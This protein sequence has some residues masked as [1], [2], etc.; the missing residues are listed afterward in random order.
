MTGRKTEREENG[1][2]NLLQTAFFVIPQ[3]KLTHAITI[4]MIY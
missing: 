1:V 3:D 2:N 4:S